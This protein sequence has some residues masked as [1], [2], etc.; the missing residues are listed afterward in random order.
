M[1]QRG[2]DLRI[3]S[4]GSSGYRRRRRF[5]PNFN[6]RKAMLIVIV[7]ALA[8]SAWK[9][10]P[11][12]FQGDKTVVTV[13]GTRGGLA[14]ATVAGPNGSTISGENGR[15]ALEFIAPA[16][17]QI[18]APGY[19][20][21][22][23]PIDE[24]PLDQALH[25]QLEPIRVAGRVVG[26]NGIGVAAVEVSLGDLQTQTDGYGNF[27]FVEALAGEVT[28]SKTAWTPASTAWDGK[29]A[30]I[31]VT[32]DP[33]IVRGLR[34]DGLA[35][36]DQ[37]KYTGIL[38]MAE[39]STVNTLIFDT[40]DEKGIVPY[41]SQV[42]EARDI[43]AVADRYQPREVLAAAHERGLY[44]ITRVVTFQDPVRAPVREEL[45]L[46]NSATGGIWT[47]GQ[48]LGWMDPTDREAWEYPLDLAVEACQLGFDEI[49]FD[50]VRFPTDGDLSV[51]Q[52]DD[53]TTSATERIATV[54]AFL[55]EAGNR[56]H[57][58]GCAVSAD[59]FAIVMSVTDDQML[60]QR[61]EEL[62]W[63][64]DAISPMIYASHYGT[65]WL[66]FD[67][68]VDHPDAVIGNALDSGIPKMAG[69]AVLRPW[70]QGWGYTEA[71]IEASIAEAEERGVGW[72]LWHS[73]SDHLMGSLPLE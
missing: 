9:L 59:V 40:K 48:G 58:L 56:L 31:D 39:A 30:R 36:G 16:T 63:S 41:L 62:S 1:A 22:S 4:S 21:A 32:L 20:E 43:G 57:P 14:G 13:L 18:S 67:R 66:G 60:G 68:P 28:A 29:A 51:V 17:L 34:V 2:S 52:Y 44:T 8:V 25:L 27:E 11:T 73:S 64:V 55:K 50:Y 33:F 42:Q 47:T 35:A 23:F 5:L 38:R 61:P 24:V 6:P 7:A 69:G 72:M 19:I 46:H 65:G 37:E 49:Q 26:P 71:Q 45:A 3:F 10:I 53:P 54:D 15:A 12:M 70:I